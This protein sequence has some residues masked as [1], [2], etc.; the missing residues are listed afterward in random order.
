M[1]IPNK[2][3]GETE[4]IYIG[5][6][7]EAISGEYPQEQALAICY[8]KFREGMSTE[9]KIASKL[10]QIRKYEGL[11]LLPNGEVNMIEPNPCWDGYE[12]IGTKIVDGR[13]VPNCVPIE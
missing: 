8:G 10:S 6:C 11:N 3:S 13:E 12:A 2:E 9:G 1:P 4:D 5:R 7:M